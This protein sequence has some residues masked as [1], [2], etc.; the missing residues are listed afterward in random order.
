MP[1]QQGN[2]TS[3]QGMKPIICMS[4][5]EA[6]AKYEHAHRRWITSLA[7][8]ART[9]MLVLEVQTTQNVEE[10]DPDGNYRMCRTEATY[11]VY[12][13]LANENSKAY[14]EYLQHR[15]ESGMHV[16]LMHGQYLIVVKH[17]GN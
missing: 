16:D 4:V 5:D 12:V 15:F 9:G 8:T 3:V 6:K 13:D 17:Y 7:Y 11:M 2:E 14:I 1:D 10:A